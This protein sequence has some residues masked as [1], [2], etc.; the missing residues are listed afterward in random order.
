[1]TTLLL[2]GWLI[3]S[4]EQRTGDRVIQERW[5]APEHGVMHGEGATTVRGTVVEREILRI[6]GDGDTLVYTA[7]PSGQQETAFRATH[8]SD[9]SVTFENP[10]H[11]FPRLI[12]Y[13]RQG[14]DTV[15]VYLQ[16]QTAKG[17]REFTLTYVRVAQP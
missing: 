10:Q 13:T 6:H 7:I 3:G 1:M 15:S 5:S 17:P 2:L 14:T 4:W 11:D 16:G 8:V 9:T 12:R